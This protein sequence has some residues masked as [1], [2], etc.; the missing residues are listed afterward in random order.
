MAACDAPT[1]VFK[2][3]CAT[4]GCHGPGGQQPDLSGA[5][6]ETRLIG[7]PGLECGNYLDSTKP[8]SGEIIKKISGT[9]C[10]T[11]MPP[12]PADPLTPDQIKCVTDWANSKLP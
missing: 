5:N 6:P 10:I 12:P 8:A 11:Q 1:M 3:S 2:N 4:T 9:T 7:K